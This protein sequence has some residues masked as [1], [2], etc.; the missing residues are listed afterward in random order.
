MNCPNSN[1]MYIAARLASLRKGV[2]FILRI[3]VS[4]RT[5]ETIK[6]SF[7]VDI[8]IISP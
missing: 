5:Y 3:C 7:Y 4:E 1:E 2:A 8:S 6:L